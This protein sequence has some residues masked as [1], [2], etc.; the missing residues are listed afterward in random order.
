MSGRPSK[1]CTPLSALS[2]RPT[3]MRDG[4]LATRGVKKE[5]IATAH[6]TESAEALAYRRDW[7]E[8]APVRTTS[9]GIAYARAYMEKL[10]KVV[11]G[12]AAD[13]PNNHRCLTRG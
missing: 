2:S 13:P 3:A 4:G 11:R 7:R 8:V 12:G 1:S 9:P 10:L 6:T 5:D